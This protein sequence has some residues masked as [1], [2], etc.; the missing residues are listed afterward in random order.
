MKCKNCETNDALKYSKYSTGEFCSRECAR[1]FSTKE[2]RSE[3]NNKVSLKLKG[4]G[5]GNLEKE[6]IVCKT[7]FEYAWEKRKKRKYCSN[8]CR[9][10]A[11]KM[12]IHIT[13]EG[14]KKISKKRKQDCKNIEE[15]KRLRDIGMKGGFGKRGYTKN[16]T[17]YS[18]TIEKKCFELLEEHGIKFIHHKNIPNSSKVSDIYIPDLDYWIEIDGMYRE[19]RKKSIPKEYKYWLEK[20]KIY[21]R[22]NLNLKIAHNDNEF[23]TFLKDCKLIK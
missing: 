20:L 21:K 1:G 11:Q 4:S 8:D 18:S 19:K 6:C 10:K 15:R 14:I 22:E 9:K 17:Q 7:Q 16:G 2:K 3:I 13:K 5:H 23:L 12:G